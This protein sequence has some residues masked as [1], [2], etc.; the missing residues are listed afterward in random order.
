MLFSGALLHQPAAGRVRTTPVRQA[1]RVDCIYALDLL[2]DTCMV[3]TALSQ[4]QLWCKLQ[5]GVR[6]QHLDTASCWQDRAQAWNLVASALLD[7]GA[8]A[9]ADRLPCLL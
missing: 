4:L 8:G 7:A 6:H 9:A 2:S 1:C 3:H 5:Q